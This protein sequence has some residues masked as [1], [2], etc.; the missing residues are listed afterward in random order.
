MVNCQSFYGSL[1]PGFSLLLA[2]CHR[3]QRLQL[4]S[5]ARAL[6]KLS[7]GI[8]MHEIALKKAKS[9]RRLS[10]FSLSIR[11]AL[12]LVATTH[13]SKTLIDR[14]M[15]LVMKRKFLVPE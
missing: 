7:V 10:S 3:P 6:P 5:L 15:R 14:R 12:D 13:F 1:A 9:T 8:V 2:E 11:F 4:E